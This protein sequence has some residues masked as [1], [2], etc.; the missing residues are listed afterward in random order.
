MRHWPTST[1]IGLRSKRRWPRKRGCSGNSRRSSLPFWRGPRHGSPMPQTIR[2]HLDEHCSHAIA[3][4]LR[5][6]GVNVTTATD[7]G[8]LRASDEHHL[9]FGLAE[10]RVVFTQDEDY[11]VLN[12]RQVPHR[13]VVYCHREARSI[14][15]II[16]SLVLIWQVYEPEEL[17][18]RVEY[19]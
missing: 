7:A 4:G 13:G 12:A 14:G 17:A 6:R 11:L 5:R 19:I 15:G 3:E 1:T 10:G 16:D 8:L 18:N 9:A 2:F